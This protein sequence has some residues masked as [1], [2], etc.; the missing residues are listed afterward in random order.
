MVQSAL[1]TAPLGISIGVD[2]SSSSQTRL[3]L[4]AVEVM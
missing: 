1:Q 4:I 2:S 3:F